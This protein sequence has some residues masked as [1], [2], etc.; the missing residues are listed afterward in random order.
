ML[1]MDDGEPTG[2]GRF[3]IL[4]LFFLRSSSP[5]WIQIWFRYPKI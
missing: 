3:A 5:R 2:I 1:S 4:N